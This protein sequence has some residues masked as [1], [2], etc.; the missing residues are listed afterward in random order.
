[1]KFD[2]LIVGAGPAGSMTGW[3]IAREGFSVLMIDKKKEIGVPVQC[4]EYIPA[5]LLK[6][7][8]I[9]EDAITNR[10]KGM[11]LYFPDNSTYEFCAPGYMLNRS[12]FDKYLTLNAL[13]A[14]VC[15]WLKTKF[16][17][18]ENS[19][20]LLAKNG[21][22]IEVSAKIIVGADGPNSRVSRLINKRYKDYVVAYQ[23]EL[24]LMENM[25]YT[26]VYFD[27]NFFGGYA[28]LFPKKYS[29]NVGL[30]VKTGYKIKI[31][32]LFLQFVGKIVQDRKII[33]TPIKTI[34]GLI[35]VGGPVKTTKNNILLVGDAA[36][37]THP[38]TGAGIPQAV[39]C[40]KFAAQA[41]TK[42]LKRNDLNL[43]HTYEEEW[44][45]IYL[46]ELNR[47][48]KKRKKMEENWHKLEDILKECWVSFPEY[49]G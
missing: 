38:I 10:I 37:Q 17:G 41:V 47:A 27:K 44:Q 2:V 11:K 23:Q 1:M 30:G 12:V 9:S 8:S 42:A 15:L 32:D 33:N 3:H 18:I 28:W 5:L 31:K 13:K 34:T 21:K 39:V 16:L 49:Y 35:P 45:N 6:E 14:G 25:E 43:L 22:L 19:K 20:I 4:A 7:V 29:A 24:P 40:G 46:K 48:I 36:G 26:E